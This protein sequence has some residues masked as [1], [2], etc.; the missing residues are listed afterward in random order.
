MKHL[1][2]IGL[3][4]LTGCSVDNPT[5]ESYTEEQHDPVTGLTLKPSDKMWVSFQEIVD[6]YV[7]TEACLGMAASG[8]DVEFKSFIRWYLGGAWG[9]YH[10]AGLVMINTDEKDT[11]AGFPARDTDT[12]TQALKHEFVHHILNVNSVP[13]HD[14]YSAEL[15]AK[16]GRGVDVS[17]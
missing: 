7:G 17:N 14:G 12:D 6:I 1:I 5:E 9:L 2:L 4:A 13:W 10:P 11:Y 16:C 3:L 8:P 15:F